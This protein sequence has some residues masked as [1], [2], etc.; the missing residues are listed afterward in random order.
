MTINLADTLIMKKPHP[1]GSATWQVLRVGMDFKLRCD[2]CGHEVMLPRSKV[3]KNIK[4][5]IPKQ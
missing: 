5:I 1:C 3:E 2:G 4:E